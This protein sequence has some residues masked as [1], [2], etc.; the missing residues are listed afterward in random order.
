MNRSVRLMPLIEPGRP[1]TGAVKSGSVA[2]GRLFTH[3]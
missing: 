3:H 1:Q 2:A